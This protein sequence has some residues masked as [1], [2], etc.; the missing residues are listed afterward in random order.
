MGERPRPCGGLVDA[1][2]FQQFDRAGP[3]LR[4]ADVA[5]V[6]GDRL[7]DLVA[8]GVDGRQRRHRV[9][10]HRPDART[11]DARQLRVGHPEHLGAG[12]P[13]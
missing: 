10:E 6:H 13:G 7:G 12:E 9:L 5:V 11:A 4:L 3:C 8:D 2:Q 1:D